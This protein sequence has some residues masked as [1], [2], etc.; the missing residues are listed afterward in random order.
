MLAGIGVEVEQP[1]AAVDGGGEIGEAVEPEHGAHVVVLWLE[2]HEPVAARQAQR[3]PVRAV[4]RLLDPGDRAGGE[5]AHQP[6]AV[7]GPAHGEP[8]RKAAR[9]RGSARGGAPAA[10]RTASSRRPAASCR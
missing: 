8:K 5:P 9:L 4:C 1:P 3:P 10:G 2:L 7:E 6:V